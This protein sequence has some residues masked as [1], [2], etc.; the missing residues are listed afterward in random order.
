MR[1]AAGSVPGP[2]LTLSYRR[3]FCGKYLARCYQQG[4]RQA[5]EWSVSEIE[6]FAAFVSSLNRCCF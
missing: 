6:L 2:I 5:R 3:D 1:A 4:L